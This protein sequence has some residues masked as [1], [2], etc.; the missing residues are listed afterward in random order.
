VLRRPRPDCAIQIPAATERLAHQARES[1]RSGGKTVE[2][3][4]HLVRRCLLPALQQLRAEVADVAEVPIEAAAG[5]PQLGCHRLDLERARAFLGQGAQ[6]VRDPILLR[7]ALTHFHTIHE[8]IDAA[9]A[10]SYLP[11]RGVWS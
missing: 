6:A 2:V 7:Q 4:D 1:I 5:D 3:A 9:N 11:Y 8:C 10:A